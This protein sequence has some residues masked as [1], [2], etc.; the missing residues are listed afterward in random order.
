VVLSA[1]SLLLA[2]T[3][4][5]NWIYL[6]IFRFAVGLGAG[7]YTVTITLVQEFV[8]ASKRGW[9]GGA[10]SV[11]AP[12]G[13]LLASTSSALLVTFIGWR[14]LFVVGALPAL[15]SLVVLR[16]VPE[17]PRW[18]L[19]KGR[20]EVARRAAAW[21]LHKPEAEVRLEAEPSRTNEP[22]GLGALFYYKRSVIVGFL[23]NIGVI[24]GY[25]GLILWGPTLLIQVQGL[26][27]QAA[28][29]VMMMAS[30]GGIIARLLFAWLSD[31]WGRKA[32]GCCAAFS[33]AAL[34][35]FT[36]YAATQASGLAPYFWMFFLATFFFCDGSFAI[37]GPYTTEI[38]P[39]RLRAAGSGWSYGTGSLGKILGPLG[40][41]VIVGSSDVL[42]PKATL[43]AIVPAF[44]YLG[45]WL[46]LAGLTYVFLAQETRGQTLENI[47]TRLEDQAPMPQRRSADVRP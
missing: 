20:T 4:E 14:G 40:L 47:E 11:A 46:V 22:R 44:L 17:S 10:I 34:M 32:A 43:A 6:S 27:A 38:W 37:S 31:H 25:Y 1:S 24:T 35:W 7:G 28:S 42:A 2:F 29:H 5:H 45:S 21:V 16:Y 41:A 18:A 19:A 26:S 9:V 3:P 36:G 8:P 30:I 23:L 12:V 13:L 33:G 15:F 39:V